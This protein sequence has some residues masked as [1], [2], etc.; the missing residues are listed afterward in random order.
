MIELRIA[1]SELRIKKF[2]NS[3]FGIRN[4]KFFL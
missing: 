3:E 1:N 4:S 2:L